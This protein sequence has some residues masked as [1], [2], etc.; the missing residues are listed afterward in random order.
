MEEIGHDP[1]ARYAYMQSA[2]A[3]VS[4]NVPM[5]TMYWGE[6]YVVGN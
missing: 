3:A 6:T 5:L 2:I 4:T 1:A